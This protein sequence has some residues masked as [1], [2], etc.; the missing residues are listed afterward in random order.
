M[1]KTSIET[2]LSLPKLL[3]PIHVPRRL[4]AMHVS[5]R[6]S[7]PHD[8]F[9]VKLSKNEKGL[10]GPLSYN[11]PCFHRF[12]YETNVFCEQYQKK[13]I[14]SSYLVAL[15]ISSYDLRAPSS[16]QFYHYRSQNLVLWEITYHTISA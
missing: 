10:Q 7:A 8:N 14:A 1:H 16:L 12:I 9:K 6:L 5:R 3:L 2:G 15:R 13:Q 11:V 4:L